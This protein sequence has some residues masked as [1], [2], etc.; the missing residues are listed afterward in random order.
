MK[1]LSFFVLAALVASFT[2]SAQVP[3]VDLNKQPSK[4]AVK[5]AKKYKKDKWLVAPGKL[6]LEFQLDQ[7]YTLQLTKDENNYDLYLW[8]EGISV[9]QTYDAAKMQAL[10]IA[11]MQLASKLKSQVASIVDNTVGNEQL[12]REQAESIAKTIAASK[13]LIPQQDLER[14]MSV[15]ELYRE[16][17]K[18]NKEVLVHVFYNR[19]KAMAAAKRAIGEQLVR[20]GLAKEGKELHEKLDKL[21]GY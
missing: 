6:P 10:E 15:V 12:P 5:E 14:L 18:K 20:D 9:G 8:G 21:L 1:K 3:P 16:L 11:K 17:P 4:L 7:S 19:E 2:L 13:T